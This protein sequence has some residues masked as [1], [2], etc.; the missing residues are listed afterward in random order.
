MTQTVH[1]GVSDAG[2]SLTPSSCLACLSSLQ[3]QEQLSQET[4]PCELQ[5]QVAS[6]SF[7]LYL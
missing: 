3:Q 4:L 7:P 1:Q 5:L 2:N 6:P